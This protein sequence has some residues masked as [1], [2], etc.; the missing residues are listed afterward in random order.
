MIRDFMKSPDVLEERMNMDRETSKAF[1]DLDR[2]VKILED[3][4]KKYAKGTASGDDVRKS[5]KAL[6]TTM[7]RNY[8]HL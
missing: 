2:D 4:L 7:E 5:M 3:K 1:S 6:S 8:H